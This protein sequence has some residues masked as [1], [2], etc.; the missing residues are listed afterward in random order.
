MNT[1]L[2]EKSQEIF[3]T[4]APW[5][6]CEEQFSQDRL[7]GCTHPANLQKRDISKPSCPSWQ[8]DGLAVCHR[9]ACIQNCPET[10]LCC[11][12]CW[13]QSWSK[14]FD[15]YLV[16]NIRL[17]YLMLEP[18]S[19]FSGIPQWR[20]HRCRMFHQD[21]WIWC[22]LHLCWGLVPEKVS[23]W[24]S[25]GLSVLIITAAKLWSTS[26][27]PLSAQHKEHWDLTGLPKSVPLM[28]GFKCWSVLG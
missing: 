12:Q 8:T 13:Q 22:E 26:E 14:H 5:K 1:I 6:I 24:L 7:P 25:S 17:R 23:D 10:S 11:W 9:S 16:N 20:W 28:S 19:L 4:V 27:G 3:L 2:T 18:S 21:L 15:G